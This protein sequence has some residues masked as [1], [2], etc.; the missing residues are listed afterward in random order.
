MNPKTY[1]L[2][3]IDVKGKEDPNWWRQL[4]LFKKM[5]FG[6][7]DF[8]KS[9]DLINPY[10]INFTET[11]EKLIAQ[12]DFPVKVRNNALGYEI[13]CILTY[14]EYN[15]IRRTTSFNIFPKFKEISTS[16]PDS[17]RIF[18][19]NRRMAFLGSTTHLLSSL[20]TGRFKYRDE[21]FILKLDS[22]TVGRA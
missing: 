22:K 20:A 17:L 3:E 6:Q 18:K 8:S 16:D 21:G 13:E 4:D 2:A 7:N 9:C 19:N 1:E 11:S 15:K 14:F 12:T 5:F 10:H